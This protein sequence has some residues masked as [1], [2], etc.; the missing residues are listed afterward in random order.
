[1][2]L[3][4]KLEDITNHSASIEKFVVLLYHRSSKISTVSKCRK[5][6]LFKGIPP[7]SDALMQH[8]KR[9]FYQASFY[10]GQLLVAHKELPDLCQWGRKDS[11]SGLKFNG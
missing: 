6:R 1:M 7:T 3:L 8:L 10:W 5:G 2:S 9:P 4:P 11:E